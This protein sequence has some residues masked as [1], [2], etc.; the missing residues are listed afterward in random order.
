MTADSRSMKRQH[1]VLRY[2]ESQDEKSL[3]KTE[4]S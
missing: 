4:A 3:K 1:A 2:I